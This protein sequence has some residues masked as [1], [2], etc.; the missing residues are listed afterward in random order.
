MN[1]LEPC[2]YE[3]N[4]L[5][6]NV[7]MCS[8]ESEINDINTANKRID[9]I[10]CALN[11]P[12]VATY[13]CRSFFPKV[14]NVKTDIIERQIDL[15]FLVEIWEKSENKVHQIE[16]EKMLET[17]GLKYISKARPTGGGVQ[18]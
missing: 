15:S 8:S 18:L 4:Q 14:G 17:E 7:S 2:D 3:F 13:N 10:T 9:K 16:I 1:E 12:S 11:L 5:D 6:G